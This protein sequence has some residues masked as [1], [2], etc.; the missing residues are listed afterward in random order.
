LL[1]TVA[2]RKNA[3]PAQIAL[4]WVLAQKPW[5]V[6]IPGTT[7][8]HRLEENVRAASIE[9]TQEDMRDIESA[10]SQITV[11][12]ARYSEAAQRMIDR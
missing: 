4:A 1:E 9:L 6:P 11:E 2:Q 8:V 7:K 3:T 12:G 10:T 5:M